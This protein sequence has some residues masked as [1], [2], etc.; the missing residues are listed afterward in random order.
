MSGQPWLLTRKHPPSVGGMQQLSH[1]LC[2][3]MQALRPVTVLAWRHGQWGLPVFFLATFA[4]LVPALVLKRISVLHLGD[5]ALSALAWLPRLFGV[6]VAVTVHGL[7]VTW[8]NRLYQ[9][10][11]R[12]FFWRRMDAYACISRHVRDVL[13]SGGVDPDQVRVIGLGVDALPSPSAE[14]GLESKFADRYPLLFTVGRLVERKGLPWFLTEVAPKWLARHPTATLVIAGEG[15]MRATLDLA[16]SQHG[17]Q[18]QVVLLGAVSESRKAWLFGRCDLVLMP[19][20]DVAGDAEGFGLVALEA[21][22]AGRW[23]AAADLQGLRDAITEGCN[24]RRI[25]PGNV[26][27]WS[28]ALDELCTDR[29]VL[30]AL[31]EQAHEF[32]MS[33]YSWPVMVASYDR[34]FRSLESGG[35]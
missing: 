19:N 16:I 28:Q 8:P 9:L 7:D 24:G 25:A 21:G 26:A 3:G 15:P 22:Q 18:S 31:G 13:L 33:R 23:V 12:L 27:A 20:L 32:V 6:P 17:L 5:P 1:H 14:P 10:Y 2:S 4:R 11:L 34:L 35:P 30:R 29:E